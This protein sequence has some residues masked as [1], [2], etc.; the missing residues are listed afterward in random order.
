MS[1]PTTPFSWQMPTATDLVTD[2][3]ADF[4]VFGQ[5]VATSMADLLGGTSGQVL[6]KNSNTDMDFVWV[7]SDDAN[8]IQNTIVDAKGDLIAA[9]AADTPARLAV[10]NNGET[11]VADSSTSTGLRYQGLQAAGKNKIYNAN[12]QIAQRGTSFTG[13]S[14]TTGV[15]TLDRWLVQPQNLGTVTATQDTTIPTGAG[16]GQ[17]LKLACTTADAAPSANTRLRIIQK[18]EGID[19]QDLDYGTAS[20]KPLTLSFWV[21]SS[22]TGTYIVEFWTRQTS[23]EKHI[24]ASYTIATANTWQQVKITIPG[25]TVSNIANT[26]A[27]CFDFYFYLAAGSDYTSGTL[28]TSWA[29]PVTANR[30]VGQVNWADSATATFYMTAVQV[31]IGSVNTAFNLRGGSVQGELAACQRYYLRPQLTGAYTFYAVGAAR[32]TTIADF[33]YTLPVSMRVAATAVDYSNA[34]IVANGVGATVLT[35]LIIDTPSTNQNVVSFQATVASGLT[36]F[37]LYFLGN[38]NNT[39]GY[40]G[41]SAEL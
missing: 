29:T 9:S 37:R 36:Q 18:I 28:A 11:L 16:V 2:L 27:A 10:G 8:A 6:A 7:T 14:G 33:C 41:I 39:A 26:T 22:K 19:I 4:E 23:T 17:S 21:Q 30:A 3:P 32:S 34:A 25:D 20:A 15:Y 12:M 13:I 38:N 24:C 5:A 35:N 31:E 40:I 1:N